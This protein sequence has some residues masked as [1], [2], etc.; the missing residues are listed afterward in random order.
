MDKEDVITILVDKY[1]EL[2]N[3]PLTDQAFNQFTSTI[4]PNL[5]SNLPPNQ[6]MQRV[7]YWLSEH[8]WPRISWL[9]GTG[10]EFNGESKQSLVSQVTTMLADG[11]AEENRE[12]ILSVIIKAFNINVEEGSD[13]D[14]V[15]SEN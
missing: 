14:N 15:D 3:D 10:F 9:L 2:D 8:Q 1:F 5:V 11:D 12:R 6:L 13:S 4:P 7:E